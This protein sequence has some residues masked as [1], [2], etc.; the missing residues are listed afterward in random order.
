MLWSEADVRGCCLDGGMHPQPHPLP[1]GDVRRFFAHP[2]AI[3]G[4]YVL[5]SAVLVGLGWSGV[6]DAFSL[7]PDGSRPWWTL[8][9]ALPACALILLK[10]RAPLLGLVLATGVF[11]ADLLTVGGLVPLLVM[12]E[13]LHAHML[14]LNVEQR[15]RVL[16]VVVAETLI[17]A[18]TAL[19]LSDDSRTAVMIGIQFGGLIGLTYW[20][21]NSVAQSRELVELYR[22]R[23]E[24]TA[25][26]A[27]LDRETAVRG[28]REWMA[29]ELHDVVAGH[30][31]AVAIRSEAAL[32]V[33]RGPGRPG[34]GSGPERQ[35]LRAVR[36]SS[37][38]AHG[39]L[40][41]MIAVLRDGSGRFAAP[42]GRE[43]IPDL[44][45]DAKRSGVRVS[46]R[47]R[48]EGDLPA[49]VDQALGRVVQEALA[50]CVRHAS[51]AE[52]EVRLSEEGLSEEHGSGDAVAVEVLS[53]GGTSLVGP[54]LR[55]SGLG[56]Q[57]LA[58]RAHA[59]GG[60]FSAG[61]EDH[62]W[63]VR[64]RLPREP[65]GASG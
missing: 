22:Q 45:E 61:R 19:V 44:V 1:A 30:V 59:L 43:R 27:R 16:G 26:L 50:N 20:Y 29:R 57:L 46:L 48:I 55:G 23:A 3:S 34:A 32:A 37:L 49:S 17:L 36:D 52:V 5:L 54:E 12:L 15:R 62:V 21:A 4:V 47:D 6:W 7:L 10:R 65:G 13:L 42:P 60:R 58:E 2:A 39:A 56:L 14:T 38:A 63:A 41:S 24:D 11:V 31:S 18:V 28:E 33:P 35:A 64:A 51:G 8:M 9:T 40:R 53:R 25:R